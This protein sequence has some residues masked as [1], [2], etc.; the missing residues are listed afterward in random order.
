MPCTKR[1]LGANLCFAQGIQCAG[2]ATGSGMP[3]S[4][5]L[6]ARNRESDAVV[7][8]ELWGAFGSQMPCFLGWLLLARESNAVGKHVT[9]RAAGS[10]M[11]C[12][13]CSWEVECIGVAFQA[14]ALQMSLLAG[15]GSF[16]DSDQVSLRLNVPTN[17]GAE[18]HEFF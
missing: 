7:S 17:D 5:C 4:W 12:R 13:L 16:H 11:P 18:R 8:G 6:L 1:F 9:R 15:G 14:L 2:N 3:W 10:Q